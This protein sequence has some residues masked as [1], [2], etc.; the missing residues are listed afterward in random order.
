MEP[1]CYN[2]GVAAVVATNGGGGLLSPSPAPMP[3]VNAPPPFS[4]KTY[5]MVDDPSTD[6]VISWGATNN[7]FIVQDPPEFHGYDV[8]D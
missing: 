7:N 6:M 4:V 5:D 2:N 1:G 3:T 8:F